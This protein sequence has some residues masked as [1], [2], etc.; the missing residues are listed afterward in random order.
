[1]SFKEFEARKIVSP[2]LTLS[3][4]IVLSD[5]TLTPE[6]AA[7]RIQQ[8]INGYNAREFSNFIVFLLRETSSSMWDMKK[9]EIT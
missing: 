6:E 9:L 1:M 3:I 8:L 5:S 4:E 2:K 7:N